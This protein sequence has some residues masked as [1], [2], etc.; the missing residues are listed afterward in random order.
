MNPLS[1]N[2]PP[3]CTTQIPSRY[4]CYLQIGP[5]ATIHAKTRNPKARK[6]LPFV[7]HF[8][9]P[10]TAT[11]V[12]AT[13]PVAAQKLLNGLSPTSPLVGCE[14]R[15]AAHDQWVQIRI[16]CQLLEDRRET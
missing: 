2:A 6:T 1:H 4:P 16:I 5:K 10:D 8:Q 11:S 9:Q 13:T 3:T 7:P 14:C 15:L 12:K